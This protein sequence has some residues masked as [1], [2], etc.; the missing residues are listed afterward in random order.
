MKDDKINSDLT[1]FISKDNEEE[2]KQEFNES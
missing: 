1:D 2:D